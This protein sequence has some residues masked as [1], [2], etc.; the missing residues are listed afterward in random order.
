VRLTNTRETGA[1][2]LARAIAVAVQFAATP[3][4]LAPLYIQMARFG[5]AALTCVSLGISFVMWLATLLLFLV[6]R[7]GMRGVPVIVAKPG[8][9]A[10]VTTSSGEIGAFII[11]L[12]I[13]MA[14]FSV[15]NSLVI[16]PMYM[17]LRQNGQVALVAPISLLLS[18]VTAAAFYL[19]FVALRRMM[20]HAASAEAYGE[21]AG[22]DDGDVMGFGRAITTCFRKYAI[23]GGRARRAEYW[24]WTLF[25]IL[26]MIPLMIADVSMFG[27]SSGPFSWILTLIM[28]LPGLAVTVRRLHD[29]D[30]RGWW[31]LLPPVALVMMCLR[32]TTGPNRFG[33][34][35]IGTAAIAEVF[36]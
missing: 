24:F 21:Y 17:S 12:A 20:P 23:F 19:I 35:P 7:G 28:F 18:V 31:A 3:V 4:L 26:L 9:R 6:L 11:A 5:G 13:V 33:P 16:A 30:V 25:Q 29:I 36:A 10:D 14:I 15:L 1:F 22:P 32:G 34:D 2:F 27:T 8:R